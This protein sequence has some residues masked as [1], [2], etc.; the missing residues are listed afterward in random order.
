MKYNVLLH[1]WKAFCPDSLIAVGNSRRQVYENLP[2][3]DVHQRCRDAGVQLEGGEG[4]PPKTGGKQVLLP[5][6]FH[7][8]SPPPTQANLGD[9][10]SSLAAHVKKKQSAFEAMQKNEG[11]A[12]TLTGRC[13]VVPAGKSNTY[14][15]AA[16]QIRSLKIS[17]SIQ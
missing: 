6:L 14:I 9:F 16:S 15:T 5:Q 13:F 12:K 8:N 4:Y 1:S 10:P 7:K 2:N 11:E 3:R 17:S